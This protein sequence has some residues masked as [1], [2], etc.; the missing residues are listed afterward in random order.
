VERR[1]S[2]IPVMTW[3]D[4]IE[5]L[6][7]QAEP[8]LAVRGDLAHTQTAHQFSLKLL[9]AEGG[10]KRVVE[11]AVILHDVGWSKLTA[12][13]IKTAFGVRAVGPHAEELNR[14][15]ETEGAIIAE[16]LLETLFYEPN[17]VK[18]I[19]QIIERHDSGNDPDSLE[20]KIV[21]DSDKLWRFSALGFWQEKERQEVT[22]LELYH[23]LEAHRLSWFFLLNALAL[24]ERELEDRKREITER[25]NFDFLY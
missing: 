9:E 4:F 17:L 11:P 21:K 22:D 7:K 24:S 3:A 14:I 6:F 25:K 23:H 1:L 20:E 19:T 5:T 12:E 13:Q 2:Y 18:H 8:F 16:K 10:D 15:H